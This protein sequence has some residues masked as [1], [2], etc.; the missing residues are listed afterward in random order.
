MVQRLTFV[1]KIWISTIRVN[2]TMVRMMARIIGFVK[3]NS[4]D[5]SVSQFGRGLGGQTVKFSPSWSP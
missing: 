3:T 4:I 1:D 5:N 2:A